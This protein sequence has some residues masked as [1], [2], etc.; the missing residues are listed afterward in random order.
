MI[1]LGSDVLPYTPTILRLPA[2]VKSVAAHDLH[3]GPAPGR[4]RLVR[5]TAQRSSPNASAPA[6][7]G[8]TTTSSSASPN[9]RPIDPRDDSDDWHAL[10]DEA[11]VRRAR[12]HDGRHT[13]GTLLIEQGVHVRVVQEILGH[14]DIR[15]TQR[16]THVA[17]PA[18][19][20][21]AERIGKALWE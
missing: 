20:E 7:R 15:L 18:A 21:A 17:S 6:R 9:G 5:G 1:I 16:Y 11:G 14:S 4:R 19:Q 2:G 12:V 3:G 10:L 13:V 8:R